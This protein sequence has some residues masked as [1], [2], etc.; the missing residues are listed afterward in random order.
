MVLPALQGAHLA[1]LSCS[2]VF[3]RAVPAG[4]AAVH[5]AVLTVDNAQHP[6]RPA[7]A[8]QYNERT[9]LLLLWDHGNNRE[10]HD[11]GGLPRCAGSHAVRRMPSPALGSHSSSFGSRAQV[12]EGR[13]RPRTP[14]E[15]V[16]LRPVR[17]RQ[18]ERGCALAALSPSRRLPHAPRLL[19]RAAGLAGGH[20]FTYARTLSKV[21]TAEWYNYNDSYVSKMSAD[22]V[23]TAAAY[24][25]CT[26]T[27]LA[28]LPLCACCS[29]PSP[30][31]TV[32]FYQLRSWEG[33]RGEPQPGMATA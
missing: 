18:P 1:M 24:S 28:S 25:E 6:R 27:P 21:R 22:D 30:C 14:S 13:R 5:Q 19:L 8:V 16:H 29:R 7:Q 33:G 3:T 32:L 20:Y 17:R 15:G 23:R 4:A 26:R 2:R 11:A 31:C 10:D 9:Q 12:R